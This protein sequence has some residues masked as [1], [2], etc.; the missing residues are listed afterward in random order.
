VKQKANELLGLEQLLAD[1]GLEIPEKVN[2]AVLVGTSRGP[3]D[4]KTTEE[5]IEIRTTWGD[6]A[7][8][9]GGKE[10]FEMVAE[11]DKIRYCAGLGAAGEAF[12]Q[13]QPLSHSH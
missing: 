2:R 3:Q 13:I 4:I 12:Y 1:E 5:G 7:W 6:M 8:Q 9:L 10:A 11:Q